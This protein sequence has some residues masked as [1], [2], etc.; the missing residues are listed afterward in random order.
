LSVSIATL[1][2]QGNAADFQK[3]ANID[4]LNGASSWTVINGADPDGI[5]DADDLL[6]WNSAVAAPNISPLG[7]DL[8]VLGLQVGGV[9]G[10]RNT[11][12]N[13]I[14]ITGSATTLT[15]GSG[16]IDLGTALQ[17][18]RI[19][20]AMT[21]AA[22][23]TW[24]IADASTAGVGFNKGE[25][26][27]FFGMTAGVLFNLGG[28]TVTKTGTGLAAIG[29]GYTLSNGVINVTSR[30]PATSERGQQNDHHYQTMLRSM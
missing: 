2:A 18:L 22:N 13:Y 21:L 8:S 10:A 9:A 25:D 29:T 28:F 26:L 27:C 5:P 6:I 4:P 1:L 17:P 3:V 15:V 19:E 11:A 23:Q 20:T 30:H 7:G 14:G 16:G 12:A 24:N